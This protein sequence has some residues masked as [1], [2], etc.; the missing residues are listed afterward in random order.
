MDLAV[1]VAVDLHG[2][3]RRQPGGG[4][5]V[6]DAQ[7]GQEPLAGRGD[8]VHARVVVVGFGRRH[9]A[10]GASTATRC[11]RRANARAVDRPTMPA[12]Q[13]TI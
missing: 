11:P 1:G 3:Y 6:P 9:Q 7:A 12:P 4:H 10:R 13:T 2:L 8:R 5:G